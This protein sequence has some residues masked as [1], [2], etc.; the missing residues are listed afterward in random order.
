MKILFYTPVKLQSGGGCERWH[1]DITNSLKKQ[2]GFDIEIISAN[3]GYN[4]WS[5][6]YLKQQLQ[7]TPY[8]QLNFPILFG[9]IIPTPAIFVFLLK[10]F[11]EADNVHFIH[12]FAGQD[13]LIAIL[14][15]LT[16]KKVVVGHHAP[17]FHSS[18]FHNFYMKYV[19]RF[20]LKFFDFHQTLNAQDKIFLEQTWGIK[21][22]YFIPSGVRVGKF[23]KVKRIKDNGLVFISVGRYSLQKGFD[24]ALEAIAKFNEVYKNNDAK[25]LFIG[26]G[27]LKPLIQEYSKKNKNIIDFGYVTYEQIP[28]LYAKS[29]IYLLSSREEPFGLVL[30]E[31]W[32]SGIPVLATKTEGP[33]DMLKPG[34]N[35]WFIETVNKDGIF[36]G[37]INIYKNYLSGKSYLDKFEL[38]CRK[39]GK[40][41]SIDTTAKRMQSAFFS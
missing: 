7:K 5:S 30:V 14:K 4:H 17:I 23:L 25:F 6:N 22:V 29:D 9:T 8:R 31:A 24:I 28:Q 33:K 39:T 36:N 10:K 20:V 11:R 3:L 12:G 35:G 38:N 19:A 40:L 16:G 27:E 26:G 15:L 1:C 37:I 21:H 13:I 18:K 2:F 32:S 41:F 34:I